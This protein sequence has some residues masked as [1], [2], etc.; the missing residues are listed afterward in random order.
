M[1]LN[2]TSVCGI[3]CLL[4]A[5]LLLH[6]ASSLAAFVE[7]IGLELCLSVGLALLVTTSKNTP[8]VVYWGSSEWSNVAKEKIFT[9][10]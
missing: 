10:F 9:A 8:S 6:A 1:S 4:L 2:L 7:Q 5:G 3:Q